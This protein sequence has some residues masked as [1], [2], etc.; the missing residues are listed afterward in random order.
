MKK[1]AGIG[2]IIL[3]AFTAC[4]SETVQPQKKT[5]PFEPRRMNILLVVID[6]ARQ[7]HFSTYGYGRKTSPFMDEMAGE[8]IVFDNAYSQVTWTKPSVSTLFTSRFPSGH[9]VTKFSK[10]SSEGVVSNVLPPSLKTISEY[11]GEAGYVSYGFTNNDF[12]GPELGFGQGFEKYQRCGPDK[13]VTWLANDAIEKHDY[14]KPFFMYLHYLGPHADYVPP[15]DFRDAFRGP[16]QTPFNL[17]GRHQD[18]FIERGLSEGELEYVL[19]QYDAEILYVDGLVRKVWDRIVELNLS[20]NTMLIIASDHGEDFFDRPGQFGH[21]WL[22][23]ESQSRI[24]LVWRVPGLDSGRSQGYAGLVDVLPTILDLVG[25]EQSSEMDGSSLVGAFFSDHDS[26]E[27]FSEQL[28]STDDE[29]RE[30]V[31]VVSGDYKLIMDFHN[32]KSLLFNI[33]EDPDETKP[34]QGMKNVRERLEE[35]IIRYRAD[36]SKRR[37]QIKDDHSVTLSAEAAERLRDIGYLG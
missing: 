8:S 1:K 15:S 31:A 5:Y 25:I 18:A 26:K 6:A 3:M 37:G 2:L 32:D 20:D 14:S 11:L 22:P 4:L 24:P 33:K 16:G 9:G 23:Y 21:G 13:D 29:S 36:A 19:S 10:T 12:I 34:L 27:V 35:K 28:Q 17:S 7:D 30:A